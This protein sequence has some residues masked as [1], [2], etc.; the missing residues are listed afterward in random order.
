MPQPTDFMRPVVAV[1][2]E[3]EGASTISEINARVLKH[4]ALARLGR[5]LA[6][7][8]SDQQKHQEPDGADNFPSCK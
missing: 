2:K 5:L 4:D 6:I 7:V 1:L 3:L 8:F